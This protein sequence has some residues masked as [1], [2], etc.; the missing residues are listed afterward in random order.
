[1]QNLGNLTDSRISANMLAYILKYCDVDDINNFSVVN[2]TA[3]AFVKKYKSIY[4]GNFE[5]MSQSREHRDVKAINCKQRIFAEKVIEKKIKETTNNEI[6]P[7]YRFEL[8]NLKK[9]GKETTLY[10]SEAEVFCRWKNIDFYY[11]SGHVVGMDGDGQYFIIDCQL[12]TDF[13]F[14]SVSYSGSHLAIHGYKNALPILFLAEFSP[15][16]ISNLAEML[17]KK[18]KNTETNSNQPKFEEI[19]IAAV[20]DESECRSRIIAGAGGL[21]VRELCKGKNV[22]LAQVLF[23]DKNEK[24]LTSFQVPNQF[25]GFDNE[26]VRQPLVV[27]SRFTEIKIMEEWTPVV[28][29][30]S[31]KGDCI[32]YNGASNDPGK[33]ITESF[34]GIE[35]EKRGDG[36]LKYVPLSTKPTNNTDPIN[37]FKVEDVLFDEFGDVHLLVTK[38]VTVAHGGGTLTTYHRAIKS[39]SYR[40]ESKTCTGE[41]SWPSKNVKLFSKSFDQYM[42]V[43]N[44]QIGKIQE[45]ENGLKKYRTILWQWNGKVNNELKL[46][47]ISES[48]DIAKNCADILRKE[49]SHYSIAP[50]SFY[51]GDMPIYDDN[52]F[53]RKTIVP[54]KSAS[55]D[56]DIM[57][58][59][60]TVK[61]NLETTTQKVI[62]VFW[63]VL[64]GCVKILKVFAKFFI[65]ALVVKTVAS[66]IICGILAGAPLLIPAISL[67]TLGWDTINV[68][69]GH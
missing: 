47:R 38:E 60:I 4:Q 11:R 30:F 64:E 26:N 43:E 59:P 31:S 28:F 69:R 22:W 24:T 54:M 63:Q 36:A 33:N 66:V 50:N 14:S 19:E 18:E 17:L 16:D 49:D 52:L 5:R 46:T 37:S 6:D 68:I 34:V 21:W 61:P 7:L 1:M 29:V 27:H 10:S 9:L 42:L 51:S 39:Y 48:G 8:I 3:N 62:R 44:R 41:L 53:G 35:V 55:S 13:E 57:V 58:S 25:S 67:V 40:L 32:I 65:T 20:K 12:P 23:F 56:K 15:K 45:I 2:K